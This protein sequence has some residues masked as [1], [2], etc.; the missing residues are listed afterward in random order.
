MALA[1]TR[2]FNAR[3]QGFNFLAADGIMLEAL[4][5]V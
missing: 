4:S 1:Q 3:A 2:L 5:N